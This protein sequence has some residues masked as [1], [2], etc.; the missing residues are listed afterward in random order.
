[1]SRL[2]VRAELDKLGRTLALEPAELA[3]LEDVPAE[4]LRALR[5]AVYERLFDEDSRLFRRLALLFGRL[6]P[7]PSVALARRAGPLLSARTA[8]ELTSQRTLEVV[9]RAP[10]PFVADICVNLDPRR[11]RD[12]LRRLPVE[13]VVA[14]ARELASRRDYISMSRFVDFFSDEAI[15][16]VAE[17]L[18][19]EALMWVGFYIGSKNRLDHL[20]R[21]LP[22]ERLARL[23]ATVSGG[24]GELL[25]PFLSLLVHVSYGLKRELG[26]LVAAQDEAVLET[27]VRAAHEQDLWVDV[28]PTVATLSDR[29]QR[30]VVNLAVLREHAVQESIVGDADREGLWGTL[31][32]LVALMD[33]A[34][35]EAVAQ[36]VAG[37]ERATLE[38]ATQA[39][40]MGE[41]WE[42]LLDLVAR[43][44]AGK[45]GELAEIVDAL[46]QVDPELA[47]RVARRAREHGVSSTAPRAAG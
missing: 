39:A 20:L 15:V 43:M 47:R 30:R 36:I 44:P 2:A 4:Q 1:M 17:A 10:V 45:Q 6:P 13:R 41:R 46:G 29:S 9:A 38:R 18:D 19:D 5:I 12:L 37:R 27:L 26:D 25:A 33:C 23:V 11:T 8:A 32:P 31:L 3:F 24:S 21:T 34:N 22:P 28:L 7:G 16:A 14:I 42:V 40:L 35:R